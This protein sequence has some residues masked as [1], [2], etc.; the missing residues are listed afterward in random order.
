MTVS[1]PVDIFPVLD[2]INIDPVLTRLDQ[3]DDAVIAHAIPMVLVKPPFEPLDLG[4]SKW[5]A[6]QSVQ[7][8]LEIRFDGGVQ[9]LILPNRMGREMNFIGHESCPN[10]RRNLSCPACGLFPPP[11]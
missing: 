3:I 9:L 4:P 5:S 2:V 8:R 10:R 6:L 1:R 11:G 7:P